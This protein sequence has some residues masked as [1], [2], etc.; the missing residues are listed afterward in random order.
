MTTHCHRF[1]KLAAAI[2]LVFSAIAAS[3]LTPRGEELNAIDNQGLRQG[4][5]IIKGYMLNTNEYDANSTVEEG[6][7]LDNK[8][9]GHWKRYWPNGHL[10]SEIHYERNRPVGEYAVY[11]DNGQLEEKGIWDHNKNIGEFKR[12]YANGNM[13]QEFYFSD[14]GKRNGIQ[15]YFHENGKLELEVNI[16]NGKESGVMKR[17]YDDGRLKEEKVLE[18]GVLV[19]GSIKKDPKK[20]VGHKTTP[21]EEVI[22]DD[23]TA[24]QSEATADE[25]NEAFAFKPNGY[26]VLYDANQQITQIGEFKNGRLWSGKWH[27]YNSDGILIRIEI[28]KSGKYVGT[29]VITDED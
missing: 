23:P 16:I 26:N 13:Q 20:N 3:A 14:N 22:A 21:M 17:Y 24:K 11:Y 19:E 9:E 28:Y 27:R 15:K 25:P 12:W 8:K 7:Y 6:K 4:Y 5:W 10:K 18:N 2:L 29:G 1:T